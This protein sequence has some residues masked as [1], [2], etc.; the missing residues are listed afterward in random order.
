MTAVNFDFDLLDQ[1]G[2]NLGNCAIWVQSWDK[3]VSKIRDLVN[4]GQN[5]EADY[6]KGALNQWEAMKEANM[7]DPQYSYVKDV[8]LDMHVDIRKQIYDR[9]PV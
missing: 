4:E 9:F 2:N 3:M 6:L 1:Y 8:F 7:G 5:V